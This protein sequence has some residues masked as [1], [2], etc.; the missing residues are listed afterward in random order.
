MISTINH[1]ITAHLLVGRHQVSPDNIPPN[2]FDR[3]EWDSDTLRPNCED[4]FSPSQIQIS[5]Q[6]IAIDCLSW[7]RTSLSM[8]TS[9]LSH[10]ESTRFHYKNFSQIG[11]AMPN[12]T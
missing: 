3:P 8:L 6:Q 4:Q 7:H 9:H 1:L 11:I 5:R 2:P 12:E 10:C